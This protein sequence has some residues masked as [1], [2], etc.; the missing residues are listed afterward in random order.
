MK[1]LLI[2]MV[3]AQVA[4][5]LWSSPIFAQRGCCSY[6]S[7]VCG[8]DN[9]RKVCCDGTYSPTCTCYSP[10]LIKTPTPTPLNIQA[11][12]SFIR[13]E[14]KTY[15]IQMNLVDSDPTNY[16]AVISKC[17]GCDPGSLIDFY[18]TS[19]L[20]KNIDSGRWYV[21][22]KKNMHG[23][24]WSP[25]IYWTIDVPE[26]VLPTSI[27]TVV[28]TSQVLGE[29]TNNKS[30]PLLDLILVVII[31]GGIF[32]ALIGAIQILKW[33]INIFKPKSNPH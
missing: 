6:H 30:S 9:G 5:F 1:T 11:N 19:F 24:Y 8:C 29:S 14:N 32:C 26:W 22:V 21:N 15:N 25:I 13:Q 20:F 7:G 17:A 2:L 4:V 12:W 3:T 33:L 23:Q 28:P 18:N 27:P 10:P 16:S 31:L